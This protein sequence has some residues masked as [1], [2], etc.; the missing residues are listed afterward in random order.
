[1]KTLWRILAFASLFVLCE[2]GNGCCRSLDTLCGMFSR[3]ASR[4]HGGRF[5]HRTESVS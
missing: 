1:M 4:P 2:V 5:G 3:V